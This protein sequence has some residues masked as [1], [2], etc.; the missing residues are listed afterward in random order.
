MFNFKKVVCM[1]SVIYSASCFAHA[2][3][4][5]SA[6]SQ[7]A[8]EGRPSSYLHC[9]SDHGYVPLRA[10]QRKLERSL[11]QKMKPQLTDYSKG[12]LNESVLNFLQQKISFIPTELKELSSY[13]KMGERAYIASDAQQ[14]IFIRVFTSMG[15]EEIIEDP[16]YTEAYRKRDGYFARALSGNDLMQSLNLT[17]AKI[18]DLLAVGRCQENGIE[19][20]LIA[21]FNVPGKT[22]SEHLSNIFKFPKGSE[23]RAKE[24]AVVKRALEKLGAALAEIHSRQAVPQKMNAEIISAFQRRADKKLKSYQNAGGDQVEKIKAVLDR[25]IAALAA[26]DANLTY[27]HGSANLKKFFYEPSTDQLSMIDLYEASPSIGQ[28]GEPLG[29]FSSHDICSPIRDIYVETFQYEGQESNPELREEL[30]KAFMQ[31]YRDRVG[32]L[33]APAFYELEK[34]LRMMELLPHSLN[35][36]NDLYK[37]KCL[38]MCNRHFY[39]NL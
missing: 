7:L 28:N 37:Q 24:I 1:F 14:E 26:S 39:Q 8:K 4:E 17:S 9:L 23:D 34:S 27:Y 11:M 29:L 15:E 19:Y 32:N 33:F 18:Q 25:Q 36:G 10:E 38:E 6:A 5:L 31:A 30:S 21:G 22:I 2:D 20:Y 3:P 12:S 13:N 35:P 16:D